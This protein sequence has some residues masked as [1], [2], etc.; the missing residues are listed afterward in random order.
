MRTA[1]KLIQVLLVALLLRSSIP[2][3]TG[4]RIL[5]HASPDVLTR[6]PSADYRVIAGWT[7]PQKAYSS[8]NQRATCM[9]PGATHVWH[10]YSF[11]NHLGVNDTI[12]KV[13]IGIEH[14]ETENHEELELYLS[15]DAGV[16]WSVKSRVASEDVE[17]LEWIDATSLTAWDLAKLSDPNLQVKV[18]YQAHVGGCYPDSTYF[19][20]CDTAHESYSL[21]SPGEIHTGDTVLAWH[22]ER[23]MY[24]EHVLRVDKHYGTWTLLDIYSGTITFHTPSGVVNWDKHIT[25]TENHPVWSPHAGGA[26]KASSLRVG[27]YLSHIDKGELVMLP[28]TRIEQRSYTGPVYS[29][30]LPEK[31]SCVFAKSFLPHE[32]STLTHV[33]NWRA[34]GAF[35]N[36]MLAIKEQWTGYIDWLPVRVTYTP[37]GAAEVDCNW[38]GVNQ[39]YAGYATRFSSNWQ[40]LNDTDGLSHYRFFSNNTGAWVNASW[41]NSWRNVVWADHDAALNG[42]AGLIIAFRF[43]VNDSAGSEYASTICFFNVSE[44]VTC[45]ELGAA[46]GVVKT[47]ADTGATLQAALA[48]TGVWIDTHRGE[49]ILVACVG[50]LILLGLREKGKKKRR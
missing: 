41:V 10:N 29:V 34:I 50:G 39:T 13:E 16:S 15:W 7:F 30:V 31:Q 2:I 24:H 25:V 48:A 47:L 4:E 22:P 20:V 14:Y 44:L 11:Q 19:V 43:Y 17:V 46:G 33:E 8:D 3:F 35:K 36:I 45:P 12:T 18:K 26:V 28:I 49:S 27:N 40:D 32:L 42:T 1:S 37:A 21:K 23:G 38:I 9:I 5:V 6:D